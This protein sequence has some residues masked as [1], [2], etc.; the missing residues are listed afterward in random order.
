MENRAP[1]DLQSLL[2]T[3]KTRPLELFEVAEIFGIGRRHV[4][5]FIGGIEGVH[6]IGRRVRIPLA[7]CPVEYLLDVGL[8]NSAKLSESLQQLKMIPAG[9]VSVDSLPGEGGPNNVATDHTDNSSKSTESLTGR[10]STTGC[11]E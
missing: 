9:D 5:D 2:W 8:L 7:E 3:L 6:R 4:S 1:T 11:E 10:D